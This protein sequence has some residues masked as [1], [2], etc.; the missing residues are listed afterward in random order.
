MHNRTDIPVMVGV[1]REYGVWRGMLFSAMFAAFILAL[2]ESDAALAQHASHDLPGAARLLTTAPT[3]PPTDLSNESGAVQ[4]KLAREQGQATQQ[5]LDWVLGHAAASGQIRAGEY[6]VAYAIAPPEGW[7]DLQDGHLTW[8]EPRGSNAHLRVIVR[9][10]ADGRIVPE[11][12]V[13]ATV[14][15]AVGT[16]AKTAI[17]PFG[18]YPLL[19]AY[20][21]NLHLPRA[22]LYHLRVEISPPQFRR[23]DPENGERFTHPVQAEFDP[24]TIDP[25]ALTSQR[26]LSD[27]ATDQLAL[28][29]AQGAALSHTVDAMWAQAV[30]GAARPVGDYRVGYAVEYAEAYWYYTSDGDFEYKIGVEQ[31]AEKNAHVEVVPLDARSGRFIPGLHVTATLFDTGG[32]KIGTHRQPFMWHPWLYHYG[33][34]WRIPESGVYKLRVRFQPPEFRRY[35]RAAGKRFAK[36]VDIEFD[37]VRMETGQK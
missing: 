14:S 26:P 27:F 19:N 20:G 9:D 8:H 17:L 34:N 30:S 4:L 25:Q 5:A 13:R 22:G 15:D 24:F 3:M 36:P 10:G 12:N 2:M 23:H 28:A 1:L 18:W 37:H 21:A 7:Y 31:S 32:H 16:M 11:L 29:K 35:G 33:E 6:K